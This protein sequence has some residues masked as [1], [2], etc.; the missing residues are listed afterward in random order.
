MRRARKR[1]RAAPSARGDRRQD[2]HTAGRRRTS[3]LPPQGS[4]SDQA[5]A[6]EGCGLSPCR[7]STSEEAD[8]QAEDELARRAWR[9]EDGQTNQSNLAAAL[10]NLKPVSAHLVPGSELPQLGGKLGAQ[11]VKLRTALL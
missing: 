11:P 8:H 4:N 3:R 6:I 9:E 10:E 1:W 5:A 7:G 2:H